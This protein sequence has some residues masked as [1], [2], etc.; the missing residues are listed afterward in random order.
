M[1]LGVQEKADSYGGN[2]VGKDPGHPLE[3]EQI[4]YKVQC[5]N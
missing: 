4:G 1:A 2:G 5:A 3:P